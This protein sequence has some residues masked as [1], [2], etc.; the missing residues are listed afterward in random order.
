MATLVFNENQNWLAQPGTDP[1]VSYTI[2]V[3]IDPAIGGPTAKYFAKKGGGG[4]LDNPVGAGAPGGSPGY[5]NTLQDAEAACQ[6]DH[7]P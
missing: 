1:S 6:T 5:Y 3:Y 7:G 2:A 4:P